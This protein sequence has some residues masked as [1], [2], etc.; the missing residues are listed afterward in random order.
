[1]R[2][3]RPHVWREPPAQRA[4]LARLQARGVLG[5]TVQAL[6][7]WRG[8]SRQSMAQTLHLMAARGWV[9]C[10]TGGCAYRW[11]AVA[12]EEGR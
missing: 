7:Q 8:V 1:M 3:R 2:P 12:Q 5:S 4:V 11:V 10:Q 9:R 6:A